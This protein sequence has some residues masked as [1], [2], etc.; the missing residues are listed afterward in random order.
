MPI[1]ETHILITAAFFMKDVP[2]FLEV[3][4]LSIAV[5]LTSKLLFS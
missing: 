3:M 5:I 4:S 1:C 2:L